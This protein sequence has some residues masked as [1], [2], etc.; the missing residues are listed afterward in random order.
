M[1]N[2]ATP[3]YNEGLIA[4]GD[5]PVDFPLYRVNLNGISIT[6]VDA[7]VST[8]SVL[9]AI[10]ALQNAVTE[11]QDTVSNTKLMVVNAPLG[12][13]PFN[14]AGAA[15][16]TINVSQYIPTGYTMIG[17][18]PAVSGYFGAHFYTCLNDGATS[19]YVQIFRVS[20]TQAT[21]SPMVKLLCVKNL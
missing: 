18:I 7:L 9:D 5:S 6:S 20:G 15:G 3:A 10:T 4:D 12:T 1:S 13:L 19:V 2:P 14:N 17:A 21:T 16:G 11:L 8:V